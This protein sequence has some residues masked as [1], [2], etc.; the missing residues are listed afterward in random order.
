MA[1]GE[2]PIVTR[3]SIGKDGTLQEDGKISFA[4][5]GLDTVSLDDW[6]NAFVSPTKAYL[7]NSTSG[8][9]ILWNPTSLEITSE[10]KSTDLVHMGVSLDGS[11]AAVR[12]NRLYRSVF[13]KDWDAFSS[14][15]EQ[16]IATFDV[17]G[18]KRVSLT[19][20]QRCPALNSRVEKDED[21]NLYFSNWV[22]NVIETLQQGAPKSCALRLNAGS[23]ALDPSWTLNYAEL[24]EGAKPRSSAT[25]PMARAPPRLPQRAR[26]DRADLRSLRSHLQHQLAPLERRSEA[27]NGGACRGDRLA[28]GRVLSGQAGRAI[29]RARPAR[30]R[31]F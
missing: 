14:S 12:G 4:N 15:K 9:Q 8:S 3:Y 17:E 19:A 10:V 21:G 26:Q 27:E 25:S 28:R 23:D 1:D 16:Y 11:G 29:V 22:Y 5:Y 31:L 6:G 24:T 18:D 7:N 30:Q 2:S 20:E 13:W